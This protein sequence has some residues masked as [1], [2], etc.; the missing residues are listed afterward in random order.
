MTLW[1]GATLMLSNGSPVSGF[2]N[3]YRW[4]G[5]GDILGVPALVLVSMIVASLGF[6]ILRFTCFGRYVY[7]DCDIHVAARLFC[8]DVNGILI[9]SLADVVRLSGLF[10]F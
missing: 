2:D 6:I 9:R 8:L 7:A 3:S 10:S 1:R 5:R 4:L